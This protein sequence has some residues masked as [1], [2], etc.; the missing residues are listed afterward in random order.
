MPAHHNIPDSNQLFSPFQPFESAPIVAVA[1]SGG[2]D[3][4]ALTLMLDGWLR[5]FG[6]RVIGLHVNHRLRPESDAE[7]LWL[8]TTLAR[9]GIESEI[10]V[11][12]TPQKSAARARAARYDLLERACIRRAILHLATAHH[13]DDQAETILMRQNRNSGWRGLAGMPVIRQTAFGRIMRPFLGLSGQTLRAWCRENRHEW[14]EDSSN[15]TSLRGQMRSILSEAQKEAALAI[16]LSHRQRLDTESR[17]IAKILARHADIDSRG[18]GWLNFENAP[19]TDAQ[20]GAM[21]RMINVLGN[22]QWPIPPEAIPTDRHAFSLG[23]C[24][25]RLQR[26]RWLICREARHQ[27]PPQ[28][29]LPG[30][31]ILWDRRWHIT[32][33]T[34]ETDSLL[35]APLG[36]NPNLWPESLRSDCATIPPPARASLPA[37]W[38]NRLPTTLLWSHPDIDCEFTPQWRLT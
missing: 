14:L 33:D 25:L 5:R 27:P 2:A 6:G 34:R 21:A 24:N 37:L 3:S 35:L 12:E 1:V 31:Q 22:C 29:L 10:L 20:R 16:G 11:W 17:D 4:L 36:Q 38:R 15:P 8:Q 18:W 23:G 7:A 30:E 32:V 13:C 19:E 26:G 9:H 28:R